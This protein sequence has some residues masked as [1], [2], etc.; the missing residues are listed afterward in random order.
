MNVGFFTL[1]RA[2]WSF[3][4]PIL[5]I[6]AICC[7][8]LVLIDAVIIFI[9]LRGLTIFILLYLY[10]SVTFTVAAVA[11]AVAV[12]CTPDTDPPPPPPPPPTLPVGIRGGVTACGWLPPPHNGVILQDLFF[13]LLAPL[14]TVLHLEEFSIEFSTGF[15]KLLNVS[16]VTDFSTW[17][18]SRLL[19]DVLLE[20]ASECVTDRNG[21]VLGEVEVER[22]LAGVALGV[23]FIDRGVRSSQ[24]FLIILNGKRSLGEGC[25]SQGVGGNWGG[26]VSERER[27][28]VNG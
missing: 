6:E 3:S 11:V 2:N 1:L 14:F 21:D 5:N 9:L 22:T 7:C 20:E 18:A 24:C 17:K 4:A 25:L 26:N 23:L 16:L 10:S 15:R 8:F 28:R 27:G 13:G 19:N 12:P